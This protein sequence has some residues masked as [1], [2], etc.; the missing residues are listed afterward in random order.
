MVL[1]TLLGV[2][3]PDAESPADAARAID[4]LLTLVR[5]DPEIT[6]CA[7]PG[8]RFFVRH[9]RFCPRHRRCQGTRRD[10]QPCRATEVLPGTDYCRV[11]QP[12]R[13]PG[14]AVTNLE[15]GP[16]S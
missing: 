10:G 4:Q 15:G 8:C 9:Q 12:G 13:E 14:R 5:L 16:I 1:A 7:A 11:H 3:P 2:E 6:E